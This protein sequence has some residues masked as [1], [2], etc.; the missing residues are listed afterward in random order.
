MRAITGHS[1]LVCE[2]VDLTP[3]ACATTRD[4]IMDLAY[5]GNVHRQGLARFSS[6]ARH[7]DLS[8][9]LGALCM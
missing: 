3:S 9:S 2:A 7:A 5:L 1:E 8:F 6:A 4:A